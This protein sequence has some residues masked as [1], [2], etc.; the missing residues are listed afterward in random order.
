MKKITLQPADVFKYPYIGYA[1]K[2]NQLY[3]DLRLN[4]EQWL[5]LRS[6]MLKRQNFKCAYCEISL[7]NRRMNIEHIIPIKRGGSN[8][9]TNLVAACSDCNKKK[10]NRLLKKTELEDLRL[11]LKKLKRESIKAQKNYVRDIEYEYTQ[12]NQSLRWILEENM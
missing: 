9:A 10:G 11:R 3:K 1:P 6:K 8:F 4:K 12:F 5:K 2:S 7:K